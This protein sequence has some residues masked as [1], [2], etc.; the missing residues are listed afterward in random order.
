[1]IRFNVFGRIIGV[2]REEGEWRAVYFGS[3]GKHR[4]APDV[5]IPPDVAEAEL[6]R[7]LGDMF[8]E[9]ASPE[10]PDVVPVEP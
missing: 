10:N 7:Y 3:D 8:H 9:S 4:P 6:V 5:I 2:T 1:M